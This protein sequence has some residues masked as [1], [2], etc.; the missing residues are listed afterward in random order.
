MVAGAWAVGFGRQLSLFR[1]R[2]ALFGRPGIG[3]LGKVWPFFP[4]GGP[5]W[6]LFSYVGCH[7]VAMPKD[8]VRHL[9]VATR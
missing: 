3:K 2:L 1:E 7:R 4:H 8:H 9:V 5:A 6:V